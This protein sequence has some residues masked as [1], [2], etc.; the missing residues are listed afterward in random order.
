MGYVLITGVGGNVGQYLAQALHMY[1]HSVIGIYRNTEP[2][3][4]EYKLVHADLCKDELDFEGVDAIIHVAARLGGS[5]E[6]LVEDNIN[7]TMNLVRFAEKK[8]VKRFIYMSSVSVYGEVDGELDVDSDIVNPTI[9]GMTKYVSESLVKEADIPSKMIIGLPRMLGPFIDLNNT[10]GSGFL[11][12][13]KRILNDED[14]TCFIPN[15]IYNNYMH[16]S[17]L[18]N[19]L[20]VLLED[21]LE[22]GYI[23]VLLGAK[24]RLSM[25]EI[26]QIMKEAIRSK[27][28]IYI[29]NTGEIAKC[30]LVSIDAAVQLGYCPCDSKENLHKFMQEL[31]IRDK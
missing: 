16:V 11:T 13:T 1:G 25:I 27:S 14:V 5:T 17:D 15:Q 18:A 21:K 20:K 6:R 3:D 24:D 2:H 19:F 7:A 26:L 4:H 12:M 23:K 22:D 30:A 10:L 9:Y 29:R 8:K 28:K 31:L